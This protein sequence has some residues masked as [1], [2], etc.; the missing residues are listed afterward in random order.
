MVE[1]LMNLKNNKV[2]KVAAAQ[3]QGGDAMERMK[4]FLSGLSKTRTGKTHLP[5]TQVHDRSDTLS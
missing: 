4:K 3:S 1:T 2:K 5:F